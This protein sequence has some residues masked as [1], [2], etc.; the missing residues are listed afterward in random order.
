MHVPG[1]K[2]CRRRREAATAT[3]AATVAVRAL[4]ELV[5]VGPKIRACR[6]NH[7]GKHQRCCQQMLAALSQSQHMLVRRHDTLKRIDSEGVQL[8]LPN[9][10]DKLTLTWDTK[11]NKSHKRLRNRRPPCSCHASSASSSWERERSSPH[12]G[13]HPKHP[14]T[15]AVHW[16]HPQVLAQ[17]VYI[18]WL[19]YG[20]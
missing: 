2:D 17:G 5:F 13:A 11:S 20:P 1:A 12:G 7:D 16:V 19:H 8:A 18:R 6:R 15:I 10:P 14:Q 4:L 3:A 9:I